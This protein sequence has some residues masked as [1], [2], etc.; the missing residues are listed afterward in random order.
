MPRKAPN[1][2]GG[3]IE[4]RI[5]LGD[6]ER[7][8]LTK[9]LAEDDLIKKVQTGTKIGQTVLIG[10]AVVGVGILATSA[11]REAAGLVDTLVDVPT[12]GWAYTK[13]RLGIIGFDELMNTVGDTVDQNTEAK[14]ERKNKGVLE[15][16]F[17]WM[18]KFLLGDDMIW[19]KA[20]ETPNPT[21]EPTTTYVVP[22]GYEKTNVPTEEGLYNPDDPYYSNSE[23][24]Y[25]N[26]QT[27]SWRLVQKNWE[28]I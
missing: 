12:S 5:T 21:G 24:W 27:R 7:K 26:F 10:G 14:E 15:W 6:Y 20:T 28:N 16:G 2:N 3:V 4:H 17:E 8:A 18:A 22:Y 25:W 19:T 13:Y 9:Q 11:Y 23:S 1:L